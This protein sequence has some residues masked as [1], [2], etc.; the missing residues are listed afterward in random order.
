MPFAKETILSLTSKA[1]V[2]TFTTYL[3]K[4]S[5]IVVTSKASEPFAYITRAVAIK[6]SLI[7][8]IYLIIQNIS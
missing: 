3:F 2:V 8:T 6:I 4:T 1:A 7:Y 5:V